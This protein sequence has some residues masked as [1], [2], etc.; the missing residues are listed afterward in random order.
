MTAIVH[1][2]SKALLW[3]VLCS[4]PAG[5]GSACTP[6]EFTEPAPV[7]VEVGP[8]KVRDVDVTLRYPIELEAAETVAITPVAVSGFLRKVLVDVGD[9]VKTGQLIAVVDCREYS[10][11]RTQAET[12]ITKWE[13]Q[14][15]ESRTRLDRLLAMGEG[16][17]VAPAEVDRAQTEARVAEAQ[18]AESRA[19]LSEAAQRQGY[20]SLTAPFD[21]FVSERFLDPGAMVSPGSRPVVNIMKT[22]AVT[23]VAWLVEQDAP[24][25]ARGA[26]VDVVLHALP[27]T[28]FRAEVAR[29]G[30][31]L[32][33]STRTLR[34]EIDL[35]NTTELLLP[36][37]TGRAAIVIGKRENTML[38]PVTAVQRLEEVTYVYVIREEDGVSKARRVAVQLG[39]DLGDWLEVLEGVEPTDSV[40]MVG[41][42]LVDDG[43]VV[44]VV[45]SVTRPRAAP[46]P[47]RPTPEPRPVGVDESESDETGA[48]A[49]T[50]AG[51]GEG[52]EGETPTVAKHTQTQAPGSGQPE[53]SDAAAGTTGTAAKKPKA[54]KPKAEK[55]KA[56]KPKAE[57]PKA[58]KPKAEKPKAEK[59][60][61]E[62]KEGNPAKSSNE[63]PSSNPSP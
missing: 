17:L 2:P 16:K 15:D 46:A 4:V 43:S 52:E 11:Q 34:V 37:M 9:K 18:L 63:G 20:C 19:K 10:A 35:P 31:S 39:V 56:E 54:E 49:S 38:V 24:K 47:E 21:G 23:V 59:P 30:R 48:P 25:V 33:P 7:R 36:G 60:K 42:E 40:I 12:A 51:T 29:V 5:F 55:P 27:E 8:P 26:E 28:T 58:E 32:D 62:S 57:K 13:A 44:E 53:G 45:D 14:V 50:T 22:R 1:R 3:W 61:P 6:Q 41:R